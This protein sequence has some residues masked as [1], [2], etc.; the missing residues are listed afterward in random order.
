M[1]ADS[2]FVTNGRKLFEIKALRAMAGF[3]AP[4]WLLKLV[5]IETIFPKENFDFFV[6]LSRRM[7]DQRLEEI[8]QGKPRRSDLL[9]MLIDAAVDESELTADNYNKMTVTEEG[10][11]S[12]IILGKNFGINFEGFVYKSMVFTDQNQNLTKEAST[13]GE[14]GSGKL[15]E[16][17]KLSTSEIIA[18]CILFFAAGY[19]TTSA[20]KQ[21]FSFKYF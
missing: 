11:N 20:G 18:N 17:R 13:K 14:G 7:L 15:S 12:G 8:K 2:P 19:E 4:T 21:Y 6:A 3:L 16:K 5:G 1:E 9:Q 10:N